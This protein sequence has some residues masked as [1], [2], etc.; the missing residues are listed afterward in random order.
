MR[1]FYCA[2]ALLFVLSMI[3]CSA[4]N[5]TQTVT[6]TGSPGSTTGTTETGTAAPG[7]TQGTGT[8]T[9]PG[10][11]IPK[12][13][14]GSTGSGVETG[15]SEDQ[16]ITDTVRA[17]LQRAGAPVDQIQISTTDG[18]VTLRGTVADQSAADFILVRAKQVSGVKDVRSLITISQ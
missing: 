8:T 15:S 5:G 6:T 16:R 9:P 18:V 17:E 2:I 14:S 11:V 4:R 12:E 1:V 3:G 13:G 10:S 7:G